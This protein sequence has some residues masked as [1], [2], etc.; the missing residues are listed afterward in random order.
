MILNITVKRADRRFKAATMAPGR[1]TF[2]VPG[3]RMSRSGCRT[4]KEGEPPELLC[5][6]PP[7]TEVQ[8]D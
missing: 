6:L 1:F 2:P 7:T 8:K 5:M 4:F 3:L